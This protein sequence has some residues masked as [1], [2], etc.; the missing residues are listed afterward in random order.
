MKVEKEVLIFQIKERTGSVRYGTCIAHKSSS[1]ERR[2]R[3]EV[4]GNG[5]RYPHVRQKVR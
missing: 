3:C 2:R 4:S 5:G 1:R